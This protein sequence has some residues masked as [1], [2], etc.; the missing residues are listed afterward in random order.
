VRRQLIVFAAACALIVSCSGDDDDAANAGSEASG[1][2]CEAFAAVQTAS[3]ESAP[4][5]EGGDATPE[6]LE[7]AFADLEA[8]FD[9]WQAAAPEE[10]SADIELTTGVL[11]RLNDALAEVDYDLFQLDEATLAELSDPEAEAADA[12]INAYGEEHCGITIGGEG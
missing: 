1:D 11:R 7:Q 8:T 4:V 10:L 3:E 5:R 6:Q 2:Y 12:R 9:D